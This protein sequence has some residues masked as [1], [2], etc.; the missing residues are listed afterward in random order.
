MTESH[1]QT[2]LETP[3]EGTMF[4]PDEVPL[5]PLQG[6]VL[7]PGEV[8]P[9][10]VFEPRYRKMIS[11]ALGSNRIIA[12]AELEPAEGT[13]VFGE[14]PVGEIGCAGL[15]AQHVMLDDGRFLLWLVGLERF[16]LLDELD[17]ETPYRQVRVSYQPRADS[18]DE[19]A[20]LRPLR[21]ELRHLLSQLLDA[22]DDSREIV[23]QQ[24]E[25]MSDDQLIALASQV[26]ELPS[27]RKRAVL[28]AGTLA[29]SYDLVF[30]DLYARL[31]E[32]PEL[33]DLGPMMLN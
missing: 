8:M 20:R 33:A 14:P 17:V 25:I 4:I 32:E 30:E 28:E 9:L 21:Q 11:D 15:I 29:E 7:L 6:T 19:R 5:F 10:H 18:N 31:G 3:A 16:R 13:P 23:D 26:L 12:M 27:D 2:M 1:N 22:D 24:L